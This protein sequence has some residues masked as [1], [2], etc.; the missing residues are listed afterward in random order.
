MFTL[1]VPVCNIATE[2]IHIIY[3]QD[4]RSTHMWRTN[5]YGA[6]TKPKSRDRHK[7][8]LIKQLLGQWRA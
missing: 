7:T 2:I 4:A 6:T 1:T 3:L 5:Y 8:N